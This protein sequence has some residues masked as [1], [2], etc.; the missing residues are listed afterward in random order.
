MMFDRAPVDSWQATEWKLFCPMLILPAVFALICWSLN[1][2]WGFRFEC[3]SVLMLLMGVATLVFCGR[4]I[5][6]S[7][8][9]KGR[10]LVLF[11]GVTIA[12]LLQMA[13]L[14]VF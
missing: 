6:Q 4:V 12:V 14:V 1:I 13:L 10:K 5:L 8:V 9:T 3:F 2:A 11:S 7:P